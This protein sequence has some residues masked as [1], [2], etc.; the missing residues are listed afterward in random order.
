MD[1]EISDRV[2]EQRLR[3]RV[4]DAIEVLARGNEG[5][6]EVNYNEFFLAFYDCWDN[7]RLIRWPNNAF[8]DEEEQTVN[9]LGGMLEGITT[10]TLHFQSEAEYIQSGCAER[11]KPVAQQAL[12]L[13]LTRGRFSED[14]EELTPALNASQT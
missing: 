3:N 11:I 6:I 10:E 9:D 12:K 4:I 1:E 13:F 7:G 2:I 8:T 5:L 14:C